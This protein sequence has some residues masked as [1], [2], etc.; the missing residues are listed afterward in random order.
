M[1]H[2][3][4]P[5][6]CAMLAGGLPLATGAFELTTHAGI[7]RR[8]ASQSTMGGPA[9]FSK[10]GVAQTSSDLGEIFIDLDAIGTVKLR[11]SKIFESSKYPRDLVINQ[12]SALDWLLR[13][14]VREDDGAGT[15]PAHAPGEPLDDPYGNFLRYCN[16]FFDP[17]NVRALTAPCFTLDMSPNWAI[18]TN[19]AFVQVPQLVQ[20][21]TNYRNHFSVFAAREAM[22]RALTLRARDGT[23]IAISQTAAALEQERK[24]YWAT[25]FRSVGHVIHLI[26]DMAQPQHTRNE[27]HG[28]GHSALFEKYIDAR[29]NPEERSFSVDALTLTRSSRT[30]RPLDYELKD[31]AGNSLA[32]PIPRFSSFTDYWTTA[33]GTAPRQESI[34]SG[35][36]IADYTSRGFLT[37]GTSIGLGGSDYSLPPRSIGDSSYQIV[38][39]NA[40]CDDS[41][42]SGV[43]WQYAK[44]TVVDSHAPDR[45]EPIKLQ[46]RSLWRGSPQ[47]QFFSMNHCVLDDLGRVLIP[48][49]VAYSAGI[50]DYFFRGQMKISMPDDGFYGIVDHAVTAGNDPVSGG[51]RKIKLNLQ[52]TTPDPVGQAGVIEPMSSEGKL[53]AVAKF[54]RN[55]CYQPNLSGEYGSPGI[56]WQQCRA[57]AEE[58][59]VSTPIAAP[60]GING[61]ASPVEFTFPSPIPISATDLYLQV[62]YRGP[63]GNEADAVAVETI[64]IS[65]PT[66]LYNYMTW[67]Q[68]K[69]LPYPS[70]SAGSYTFDQWCMQGYSD[71]ETCYR[72][73]GLNVKVAYTANATPLPGYDPA[74]RWP[75]LEQGTWADLSVE[76]ALTPVVTMFTPVGKLTRVAVL[77]HTNPT[78]LQTI[79]EERI[80]TTRGETLFRFFT[81]TPVPTIN[82]LDAQGALTPS[83]TYI[84]GRGVWLPS[85][86]SQYING[87][88]PD[89][90]L[91]IPNLNL[92]PSTIA[93]PYR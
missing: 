73:M 75:Q 49:A 16:H 77:L 34:N 22:F 20:P 13:G 5:L 15:V 54:H 27:S 71:I 1:R 33:R 40:L 3:S 7:S 12:G 24:A 63:L 2:V 31:S 83:V 32:Y 42:Q 46:S 89:P 90:N 70:L 4:G 45:S 36:G 25:T 60:S 84:G 57:A 18:G 48:R 79:V 39:E 10:L 64:D 38:V 51:F 29:A 74:Q 87:K 9:L 35:K 50:I 86:E 81:N 30:L 21:A 8:A 59:V 56:N 78:N 65:E 76:P 80:N 47:S 82:Q 41:A 23:S 11:F 43:K 85:I 62:V 67:D 88:D 14:A 19:N 28:V 26:Q 68:Y 55:T 69:Y 52:N 66:Y 92:A 72:E 53:V 17:L 58:I 6:M 44:R 93:E 61:G 91:V 37:P